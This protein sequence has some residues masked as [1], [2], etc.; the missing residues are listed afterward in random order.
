MDKKIGPDTE[1]RADPFGTAEKTFVPGG[2]VPET[3]TTP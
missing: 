3:Y 2:A 1:L